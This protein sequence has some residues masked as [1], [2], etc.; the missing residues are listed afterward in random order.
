MAPFTGSPPNQTYERTDGTRT[1]AAVNVTAKANGVNDTAAL[2]DNREN[3]IADALSALWL[4]NGGNQP[5]ANL[6]MNGF[7]FTGLAAGSAANDSVRLAQIQAG[8]L[9]YAEA[10]GTANAIEL[11]TTPAFAPAEGVSIEFVAEADSTGA[12]TVD[13]NGNGAVALQFGGAALIGGEINNGQAHRITH[14]G[15]QWQLQNSLRLSDLHALAK[16]DSN[17][18]VGDGTNWVA[19]SGATARTSLGLTIGTD[20]QAFDELLAEIAAL[21]TDPNADS[22]LF[23]DDSAGNMAYWTPSS[24]LAFSGTNLTVGAASDTAAGVV[25]IAVQSEMEARSSTTL[26]VTPGRQHYHPAHPK[27]GGNF[28]GQGT[29]AF[30][31]GDVGMGA[32]T[33]NGTGDYTLAI[34]T[35]FSGTGYWQTVFARDDSTANSYMSATDSGSKTTTAFQVQVRDSNNTNQDTPEGGIMFWG[36]YA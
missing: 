18:I 13:L 35:A 24:P 17:I 7:K 11:T 15:T 4:R 25:E 26:A 5:S 20:V 21:S 34:D 16:T 33:D 2:A 27:A 30:A 32:I 6:P 29:P 12:T 23:F 36:D 1:G 31:A 10:A 28:N 3:D 9:V 14:D 19:E 8:A 22:G